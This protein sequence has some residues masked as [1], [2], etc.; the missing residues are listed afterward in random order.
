MYIKPRCRIC[1][2]ETFEDES[3]N[4]CQDCE[5][6]MAYMEKFHLK[7]RAVETQPPEVKA[8]REGRISR[9]RKRVDMEMAPRL[10]E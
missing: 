9:H 8:E 3:P 1:N 10:F 6:V 2:A 5:T 4:L 7:D